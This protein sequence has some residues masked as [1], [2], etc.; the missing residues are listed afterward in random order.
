M[1][2]REPR[3]SSNKK[4]TNSIG[5]RGAWHSTEGVLLMRQ[6]DRGYTHRN[7]PIKI[8]LGADGCPFRKAVHRSSCWAHRMSIG[9]M[10]P[11]R[12]NPLPLGWGFAVEIP[13]L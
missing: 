6:A 13:T 11:P 10:E 12:F 4:F 3:L 2:G 5:L 9:Q 1:S 8:K 7:E